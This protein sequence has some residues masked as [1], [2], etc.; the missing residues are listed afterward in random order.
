MS[1]ISDVYRFNMLARGERTDGALVIDWDLM[2]QARQHIVEEQTEL[3]DALDMLRH[4]LP[5]CDEAEALDL[6]REVFDGAVDLAW[7]ALN[8][9]YAGGCT[10]PEQFWALAAEANMAKIPNCP[11]CKGEGRRVYLPKVENLRITA[12]LLEEYTDFCDDCQGTGKGAPLMDHNKK[13]MK[14]EGWTKPDAAQ[15]RLLR[16][17]WAAERGGLSNG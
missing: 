15:V 17:M 10:L 12:D 3:F 6:Y 1:Q 16:T 13:I 2:R 14:P 11:A 8:V 9:L 5:V 4:R 7:V